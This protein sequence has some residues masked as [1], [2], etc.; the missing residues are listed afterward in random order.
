M[1]V[2]YELSG[3]SEYAYHARLDDT[4]LNTSNRNRTNATN[5]VYILEGQTKGLVCRT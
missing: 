3:V 1:T 4:S 2:R 5:L